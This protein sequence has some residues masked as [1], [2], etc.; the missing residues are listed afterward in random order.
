MITAFVIGDPLDDS[1]IKCSKKVS[2]WT[3]D[4]Q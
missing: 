3:I 2:A 4:T 1:G